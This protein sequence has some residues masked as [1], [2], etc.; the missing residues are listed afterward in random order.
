MSPPT[1]TTPWSSIAASNWIESKF[2]LSGTMTARGQYP[3]NIDARVVGLVLTDPATIT[4]ATSTGYLALGASTQDAI[5]QASSPQ[6]LMGTGSP[7]QLRRSAASTMTDN[8]GENM[9]K[10]LSHFPYEHGDVW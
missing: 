9:Q 2:R 5:A 3:A 8:E 7:C 6:S 4:P 1:A 10:I